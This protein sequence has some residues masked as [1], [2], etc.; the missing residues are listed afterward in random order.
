M[1]A[2]A[3]SSSLM[4]ALPEG[5]WAG[6]FCANNASASSNSKNMDSKTR[7]LTED[8]VERQRARL[9]KII[10]SCRTLGRAYLPKGKLGTGTG[11][12]GRHRKFCFVLSDLLGFSLRPLRL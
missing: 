3:S 11:N 1:R 2:R 8:L 5:S 6:A 4:G 10:L 7:D 9:T 12:L